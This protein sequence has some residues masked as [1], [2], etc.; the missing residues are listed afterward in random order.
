MP[1]PETWQFR[2]VDRRLQDK[3]AHA[4]GSEVT[5]NGRGDET[6]PWGAR[7]LEHLLRRPPGRRGAR[8]L[9]GQVEHSKDLAEG[10]GLGDEGHN[11]Y[12]PV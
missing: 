1:A 3:L 11:A 4:A 10:V 7:K 2:L 6:E 8:G 5:A 9:G 12:A